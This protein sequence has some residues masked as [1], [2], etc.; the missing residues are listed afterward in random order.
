MIFLVI[1]AIDSFYERCSAWQLLLM[2]IIHPWKDLPVHWLFT[3]LLVMIKTL[4]QIILFSILISGTTDTEEIFFK[5]G[6][7]NLILDNLIAEGKAMPMIIVMPYGNPM[8]RI[9]EQKGGSKTCRHYS[10]RWRG[11]NKKSKTF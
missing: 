1:T 8:A 7:T 6:R 5:V 11:C 9:A 10:K 2:N 3:L 4:L